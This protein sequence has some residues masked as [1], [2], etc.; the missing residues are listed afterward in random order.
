MAKVPACLNEAGIQGEKVRQHKI[1]FID[2][3]RPGMPEGKLSHYSSKA[4][5]CR[6][7]DRVN[8]A[9]RWCIV[10]QERPAINFPEFRPLAS[11]GGGGEVELAAKHCH[12]G[13]HFKLSF[14]LLKSSVFTFRSLPSLST[15]IPLKKAFQSSC[16]FGCTTVIAVGWL[17]K[18]W[19]WT[20]FI[21]FGNQKQ[22][23]IHT[24]HDERLGEVD[25]K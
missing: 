8:G 5:K 13:G 14:F 17:S 1:N 12:A 23:N 2:P 21:S 11:N 16:L 4:W 19:R 10:R 7:E 18:I 15:K 25:K 3:W 9:T 20:D 22:K 6:M 24:S